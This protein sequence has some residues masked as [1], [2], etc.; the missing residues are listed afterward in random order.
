MRIL[1]NSHRDITHPLAGGAERTQY[2]IGR[3]LIARGHEFHAVSVESLDHSS[4]KIY[5]GIEAQYFPNS[6]ALHIAIP[7]VVAKVRPDVVIDDLAHVVPFG[8][9]R[10]SERPGVCFF[11]HLH[12][13]TLRG[14]VGAAQAT[15]LE[16]VERAYP[17]IYRHWP[18]VT[19]STQGVKD[20][21]A[22]G[23]DISRCHQI[24]PGVDSNIFV[25]SRKREVP[26]IVY[27]GG[28]K[29]YKRPSVALQVQARLRAEG[30]NSR[31]IMIGSGP[32]LP[33]L[34][35]L[36][37]NLNIRS[38]VEFVGRKD[39]LD[40]ARIVASCHVNVHCSL[41]E[42]WGYSI[43]EAASAGVPTAAF[44]VAGVEDAVHHSKTGLLVPDTDIEALTHAVDALLI[45]YK[46]YS[47]ACREMALSMS[48]DSATD[49]WLNL[50][51]SL[52]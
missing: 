5:P 38:S 33:Q 29:P 43:S 46:T 3:R 18:F 20:L 26:T 39:Y 23:I 30:V 35:R 49:N 9:P 19:E 44:K 6:L 48:W 1:W 50:L 15:V 42:G 41:A 4:V 51:R 14:Q 28:M 11:R 22:A 7:F 47:D 21:N 2:E 12:S 27:F 16:L 40:L 8:T 34:M 36:A 31:L 52:E 10:F 45:S 17:R 32:E 37:G 24:R 13:R 25:P